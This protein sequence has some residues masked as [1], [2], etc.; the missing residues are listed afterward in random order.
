[1][2]REP[3]LNETETFQIDQLTV[4]NRLDRV[5]LYGSVEITYDQAGLE[6]ASALKALVDSLVMKLSSEQLPEKVVVD[7]L[8]TVKNPFI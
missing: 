5:Q 7:D 1:M 6:R 2:I 3:F 8:P 4:E